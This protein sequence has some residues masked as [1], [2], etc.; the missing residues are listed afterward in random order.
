M[1]FK[2]LYF[3][4]LLAGSISFTSCSSDN[5]PQPGG[6]D[7]DET[8]AFKQEIV[9]DYVDK[10]VIPTYADMKEKGWTLYEC[11]K[12]FYE[13]EGSDAE[14]QTLFAACGDAW[15]AMREPW[16]ESE[17]F[18]FG[19]T[20]ELGLDPSLDSWPLDQTRINSYVNSNVEFY[21]EN[22]QTGLE[23]N[24]K[25]FHTIEY[26][27]FNNG[28]YAQ[29]SGLSEQ[30]MKYLFSITKLL[31]DN[32]IQLWAAW[33]GNRNINER[34]T[35][36]LDG[37]NEE[38]WDNPD[39]EEGN[40]FAWREYTIGYKSYFKTPSL[41]NIK[42]FYTLNDCL[43]QIVDGC[44]TICDE[45]SSQ[46][47]G[48]PYDMWKAGQKE[49]AV[50]QVESWYSWNSLDDYMDNVRSIRNSYYGGIDL[51]QPSTKSISAYVA[52]KNQTLD[53]QIKAQIETTIQAINA[54]PHPFR[55]N[56]GATTEITN[57]Q[58][59]LTELSDL[60]IKLKAIW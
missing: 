16:E 25:G 17:A 57:A 3:M 59:Q 24:V 36:V 15:R 31:R 30:K 12:A 46:K 1:K 10:V 50:Y 28:D 47:I 42:N 26:F 41:T 29:A 39:T 38:D 58:N 43:N 45:V 35:R 53:T 18:L 9:N 6:G 27:L 40:A 32:A 48:T 34:D 22:M 55:N 20:D 13:S 2:N 49:A 60:I 51:T 7:D 21:Y 56:L 44:T 19:P 54:I 14:K 4:M 8:A 11:V 23:Y 52:S 33:N 37:E 5:D